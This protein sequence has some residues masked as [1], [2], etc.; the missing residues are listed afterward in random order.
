MMR[1]VSWALVLLA[2]VVIPALAY[3]QADWAMRAQGERGGFA[4]GMPLLSLFL[5]AVLVSGLLSLVAAVLNGLDFKAQLAPRR[6]LRVFE[7]VCM[8][9]PLLLGV[10]VLLA[11]LITG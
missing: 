6:L 10:A 1:S 11:L 2:V 3:W 5:L 9:A 8:A 7:L 4:C